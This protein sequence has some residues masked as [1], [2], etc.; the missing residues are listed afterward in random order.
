MVGRGRRVSHAAAAQSGQGLAFFLCSALSRTQPATP[1]SPPNCFD[2][3]TAPVCA[4]TITFVCVFFLFGMMSI[5]YSVRPSATFISP[6]PICP[7]TAHRAIT[8]AESGEIIVDALYLSVLIL[9][10]CAADTSTV[11]HT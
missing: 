4:S 10:A 6:E 7:G 2:D 11:L 8:F 5:A 1:R 3:S 9:A